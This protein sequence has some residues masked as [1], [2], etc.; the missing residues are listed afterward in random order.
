MEPKNE[1]LEDDFPFKV[2][3]FH[4]SFGGVHSTSF[5]SFIPYACS[6]SSFKGTRSQFFLDQCSPYCEVL[7]AENSEKGG[8]QSIKFKSVSHAQSCY[9]AVALVVSVPQTFQ[10]RFPCLYQHLSRTGFSWLPTSKT[11][12]RKVQV[13][14]IINYAWWFAVE[15]WGLHIA[16]ICLEP[17]WPLFGVRKGLVLRGLASKIEVI[18][19]LG[20]F[21]CFIFRDSK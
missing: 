4:V 21:I 14:M 8:K 2:F 5:K 11:P 16:I 1:G 18:W 15:A 9:L 17:K 12:R 10:H 7:G 13:A 19:V 20:A 6:F 3:R